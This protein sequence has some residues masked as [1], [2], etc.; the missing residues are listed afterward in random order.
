MQNVKGSTVAA[1]DI[2]GMFLLRYAMIPGSK[3]PS[4]ARKPLNFAIQAAGQVGTE[5][6]GEYTGTGLAFG[7]DHANRGEALVEGFA[8]A[9]VSLA[10]YSAYG[11]L[12]GARQVSQL[13]DYRRNRRVALQAAMDDSGSLPDTLGNLRT[14]YQAMEISK[15]DRRKAQ[16]FSDL[17]LQGIQTVNVKGSALQSLSEE[18]LEELKVDQSVL[19]KSAELG[20]FVPVKTIDILRGSDDAIRALE[21]IRE[22]IKARID[23]RTVREARTE[24]ESLNR[25][26]FMMTLSDLATQS[27]KEQKLVMDE[28][29]LAVQTVQ[30][31]AGRPAQEARDAGDLFARNVLVASQA[32]KGGG[33]SV[34][35]MYDRMAPRQAVQSVIVD[36]GSFEA[37]DQD[38][39][40]FY[41]D[42]YLP[43]D[44]DIFPETLDP[45]DTG[46]REDPLEHEDEPDTPDLE[47]GDHISFEDDLEGF[48][49][50]AQERAEQE[51]RAR[52]IEDDIH[53]MVDEEYRNYPP[54]Q[55]GPPAKQAAAP[56]RSE[57]V[58]EPDVVVTEDEH[59]QRIELRPAVELPPSLGASSARGG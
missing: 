45:F 58:P 41:E 12:W 56:V 32:V 15:A 13:Y 14:A 28:I 7:W 30:L 35:D 47:Y 51:R 38:P 29:S 17:K 19:A 24:L 55:A 31:A 16:E 21:S 20:S 3:M 6:M 1:W 36:E 26:V 52:E 48:A 9:G 44:A 59:A 11:P 2:A 33:T 53:R 57:T 5:T 23:G 4:A 8:S 18:V 50:A 37:Q 27:V 10:Q 40:A 39:D 46:E 54:V 43:D 22:D 25:E 49:P 42:A 34:A